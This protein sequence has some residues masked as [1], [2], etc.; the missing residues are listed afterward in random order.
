MRHVLHHH[1]YKKKIAQKKSGPIDDLALIVGIIQ[2]LA[3][4]PQIWLVYSTH[5]AS[6]VSFFMWTA[7]NVASVIL[8]MYGIKYRLAPIIWANILWLVVQ[9][10]MMVSVFF[11]PGGQ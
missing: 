1:K 5:N 2:P 7:Y 10:P 11:F 3:T 4:L 8:L 9:T 6:G